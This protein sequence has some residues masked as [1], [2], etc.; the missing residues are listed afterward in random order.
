[1]ETKNIKELSNA[2]LNIYKMELSNE[3]EAIKSKINLLCNE[4]QKVESTY[5]KVENEEK[6]RSKIFH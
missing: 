5:K 3:F 6:I 1:M 2:E 4:L